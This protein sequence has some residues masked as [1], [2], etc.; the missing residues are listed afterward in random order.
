MVTPY[1]H[2]LAFMPGWLFVLT[3]FIL[4]FSITYAGIPSIVA[5][6]R[7]KVLYELPKDRDS[8]LIPT[9]LMGGVAVFAGMISGTVLSYGRLLGGELYYIVLAATLLLFIG[10]K[11]D[12]LSI[13]PIKK[14]I[15][16]I[17]ISLIIIV[18]GDI[19]ITS[20]YGILGINTL[21]Y[22]ISILFTL[23]VFTLI[24]NAV[25]LIDG[26]DGLAS[27][28]GII[29]SVTLG[30]W[31]LGANIISYSVLSFALAGSLIAFIRFNMFSKLNKIFLGDTGS[32][33]I[34]IIVA[35]I[36]VRFL[37]FDIIIKGP[38]HLQT[39]PAILT[40][41]LIFPLFDTLRVFILRV[42]QGKSPFSADHQ[43]IHHR[44][45]KS[46]YT[47]RQST[48]TISAFNI[49]VITISLI[50]RNSNFFILILLQ[51]T[52]ATGF[53][54]FTALKIHKKSPSVIMV[55]QLLII[56]ENQEYQIK[57]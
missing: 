16:Q 47:H 51:I 7:A 41:I 35:V 23:F 56:A 33:V 25:N 6:S 27:A 13:S 29:I 55:P 53:L 37:Q 17:M 42:Y 19:H 5:I 44:L 10:L 12:L 8:H 26:I 32:L 28:I 49:L 36:A 2:F 4:S 54:K 48:V 30:L 34:G 11:D 45:L 21:P 31:F 43:H 3:G 24:I 57:K 22:L 50:L 39:A 52:L 14:M 9:P 38:F 20:F 18:M 15:V 46:G 40:G 1:V